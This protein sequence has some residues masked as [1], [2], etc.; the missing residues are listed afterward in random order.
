MDGFLD[1]YHITKFNQGQINYLNTP[2]T[3]KEIEAIIKSLETKKKK[4]HS[5]LSQR[6]NPSTFQTIPQNR[7]RRNTNSFYE[8]TVTLIPKPHK[9]ST[10]KVHFRPV[11]H[12][13]TDAKNTQ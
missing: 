9:D 12:M 5:K 11:L 13:N 4:K 8:A 7:K 6:T 2:M 1:R 3:P 10:K